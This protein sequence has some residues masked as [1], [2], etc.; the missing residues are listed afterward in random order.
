MYYQ[1]GSSILTVNEGIATLQT[2]N[3]GAT[4]ILPF[5]A[6]NLSE[7]ERFRFDPVSACNARCV[8]CFADFANIPVR[9]LP[10]EDLELAM[11]LPTLQTSNISV[12]CSYEPLLGKNFEKYP[13]LLRRYQRDWKVIIATNGL[14]LNKKDLTPWVDLGFDHLHVSIHSNKDHIYD[15]VLGTKNGLKQVEANMRETRKRFPR[16]DIRVT[17][18]I[19][20]DNSENLLDYCRWAFDE[21]GVNRVELY[22]ALFYDLEHLQHHVDY[23]YESQGRHPRLSDAEWDDA[24]SECKEVYPQLVEGRFSEN[25]VAYVVF[26]RNG[27]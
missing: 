4:E 17:N 3:R 13:A 24:I 1:V 26:E 18:V 7:I 16:L 10:M 14:N 11:S 15:R 9:Q 8:F 27:G 2:E 23:W 20:K 22:R 5:D 12:G 25:S 6:I 19:S 21:L